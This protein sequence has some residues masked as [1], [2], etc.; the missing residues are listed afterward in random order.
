[1]MMRIAIEDGDGDE[2]EERNILRVKP[3]SR[4]HREIG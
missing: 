2:K 1:M 4:A 3:G